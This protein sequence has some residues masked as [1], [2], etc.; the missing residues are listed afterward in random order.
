M[1]KRAIV[2]LILITTLILVPVA[3]KKDG[4]GELPIGS[5]ADFRTLVAKDAV[6]YAIINF[7]AISEKGLF[8]EFLK[9]QEAMKDLN[10]FK[11]KTGIDPKKDL[12]TGVVVFLGFPSS[13]QDTNQDVY[14]A[15]DGK[16]DQKKIIATLKSEEKNQF[17]TENIG[18][19]TVYHGIQTYDEVAGQKPAKD[20]YLNFKSNDLIFFA[21]N[22]NAIQTICQLADGKKKGIDKDSNLYEMTDKVNHEHM[23]W[24]LLTMPESAKKEI[25]NGPGMM[26]PAFKDINNIYFGGTYDGKALL[27]EGN[28]FTAKEESLKDLATT[29]NSFKDM[30]KSFASQGGEQSADTAKAME[31]ID[32]ILI[33]QEKESVKISITLTKEQLESLSPK[34]V[35]PE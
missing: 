32:K 27:F 34:E 6:G 17:K 3:C 18:G 25:E 21:T 15:M 31:I 24:G 23:F 9:D 4:A 26:F 8:D 19:Y 35:K 20:I 16:F 11:Q 2:G 13:P 33:S 5:V 28:L 14:F 12:G 1:H 22:K 29:L 7:K 30:V 10:E